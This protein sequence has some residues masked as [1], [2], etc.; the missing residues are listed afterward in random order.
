[1]EPGM[2]AE[3]GEV[4]GVCSPRG[5]LAPWYTHCPDALQQD[6][7]FQK[8][9]DAQWEPYCLCKQ[10]RQ[11]KPLLSIHGGPSPQTEVSSGQLRASGRSRPF[12]Q[13]GAAGDAHSFLHEGPGCVGSRRVL[14]AQ[15]RTLPVRRGAPLRVWLRDIASSL[16]LYGPVWLLCEESL[17][18]AWRRGDGSLEAF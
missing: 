5:H 2:R 9:S 1:M 7:D 10:L 4:W 15:T 16:H 17:A 18:S 6:A 11:S 14:K 12:F 3:I 8:E 13:R